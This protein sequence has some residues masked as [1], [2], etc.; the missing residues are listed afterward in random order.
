[1]SLYIVATP[2]GNLEDIT[3]RALRILKE[4]EVI[5]CE[6]TRVI[7]KL[8]SHYDIPAPRLVAIKSYASKA[9]IDAIVRVLSEG[10]SVALVSDAGTPALAD[11]GA[12][13]VASIRGQLPDVSIV[14]IP[15]PSALGAALSASG[16]TGDFFY[17][18]GFPPHKKGRETFFRTAAVNP[19]IVVM[20]ESPHRIEKALEALAE[21]CPDR[22]ITIARE[23][24]KMFEEIVSGTAAELLARL[25]E[26]S[27]KARG[28]FVLLLSPLK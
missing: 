27:N 15:G 6:D 20:Y 25:H 7:K 5:A 10:Q 13:V 4:V 2:I 24:T 11:P 23:I 28:E 9:A 12:E 19:E 18:A 1:M 3:L 22:T 8:L 21:Y 26:D 16:L 14:P 17:F